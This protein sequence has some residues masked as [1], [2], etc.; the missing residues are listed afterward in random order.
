MEHALGGEYYEYEIEADTVLILIVM[1]H[2][3]G[4]LQKQF[5]SRWECQV[6]ILIVMEHALGDLVGVE[7]AKTG[8]VLILIVMEHALGVCR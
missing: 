6:L 8:E 1:E 4:V 5:W 7:M 3:L 2:A